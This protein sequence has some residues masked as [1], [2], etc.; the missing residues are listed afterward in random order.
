MIQFMQQAVRHEA[1]GNDVLLAA[2][3][4]STLGYNGH[5]S[6]A[7]L[8]TLTH[9]HDRGYDLATVFTMQASDGAP[10]AP[11]DVSLKTGKRVFSTRGEGKLPDLPHID[12]V[13]PAMRYVRQLNLG[14]PVVFVVDREADSI[15]HWRQW[16]QD[17]H[18]ALVRADDRMVLR[19]GKETTLVKTAETLKRHGLLRDVGPASYRGRRAR[20]HVAETEVVLHKP[21]RRNVG[22]KKIEVPGEP[23]PLR[24]VVAEVH[25]LKGRKLAR[26]LLL[27]NVPAE[28]AD[29]A[30]IAHWYYYRWR[31]ETM[32]KL[33]KS[34]GHQL[35][36]WLQR[37]GR[38]IFNKLL[39][40][41]AACTAVWR[42]ERRHDEQSQECKELLMDLSGR[43]TK[44]SKPITTSGLLAGVWVLQKSLEAHA[45][46]G[47][48]K[49]KAM[50]QDH[51]PLGA[52]TG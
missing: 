36:S 18:L 28:T 50:L 14:A 32:H 30:K 31:I 38:R 3:D 20:L 5:D 48:D 7:D 42:L 47:P 12:Q 34:L 37:D 4:W 52:V 29:T 13:L 49:L 40:A 16:S 10:I 46:H 9:E 39:I 41:L 33:L 35:E 51:L 44:R 8:A 11:V 6:K 22:K 27:T 24:L 43:Q 17:G 1:S 19:E 25:D 15:N 26:W 21:G 23:L 45:R 2:F